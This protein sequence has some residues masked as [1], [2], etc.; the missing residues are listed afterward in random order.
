MQFEIIRVPQTDEQL[1]QTFLKYGPF[2]AAMYTED[3]ER[4]HGPENFIMEHWVMLWQTGAGFL[5]AATEDGK[6]LGLAMC[7]KF[8]DLWHSKNRLEINRYSASTEVAD[9]NKLVSDM[10]KYLLSVQ[11]LVMFDELY[12]VRRMQDGSEYKELIWRANQQ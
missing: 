10:E 5:L 7:V 4:I 2:L 6:L 12:T 8:R 11:T 3:D 9:G 1:E